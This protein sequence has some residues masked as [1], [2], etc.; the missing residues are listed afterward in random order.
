MR[1]FATLNALKHGVTDKALKQ[2]ELKSIHDLGRGAV[3]AKYQQRVNAI[4]VLDRQLNVVLNQYM[5][6]V[7]T[8]GYFSKHKGSIRSLA[9]QFSVSAS[10]A[11]S[12]AFTDMAF[13]AITL[14]KAREQAQFTRFDAT[15]SE[16]FAFSEQPRSKKVYYVANDRFIPAYYI[17][18]LGSAMNSP[19]LV[20]YTYI[21]SAQDG[22]ILR[23]NSM[24]HSEAA[25]FTYNVFADDSAPYRPYDYPTGDMS[26]HPT[27]NQPLLSFFIRFM[28]FVH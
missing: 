4:E 3:I 26:P 20:G 23:R 2:A 6:L 16:T 14:T 28:I 17:E 11:I 24:V 18:L 12:K 15:G 1:H 7:A 10:D 5:Q 19:E 25:P 22:S 21:M 8:S 27:C 13:D 9:S